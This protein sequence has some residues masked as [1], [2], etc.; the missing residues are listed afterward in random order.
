MERKSEESLPNDSL[1]AQ[2]KGSE[3]H[4][5]PQHEDLLTQTI[6][7]YILV[8]WR[9][10]HTVI[11]VL[12]A[13]VSSKALSLPGAAMWLTQVIGETQQLRPDLQKSSVSLR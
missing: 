13:S 2:C 1:I 8:L 10:H 4:L 9:G 6:W 3:E 12:Y 7:V 11:Q 5:A